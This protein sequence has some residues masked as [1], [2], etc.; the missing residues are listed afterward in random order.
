MGEFFSARTAT[1]GS[2]RA[3]WWMNVQILKGQSL[4]LTCLN[5][6]VANGHDL[7]GALTRTDL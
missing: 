5:G 3:S 1:E 6:I 7:L 4:I 2:G